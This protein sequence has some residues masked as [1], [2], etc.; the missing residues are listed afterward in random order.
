MSSDDEIT[1]LMAQ[2]QELEHEDS[3]VQEKLDG[4]QKVITHNKHICDDLTKSKLCLSMYMEDSHEKDLTPV[5][6]HLERLRMLYEDL[7][8]TET[9]LREELGNKHAK[10]LKQQREKEESK[11][12]TIKTEKSSLIEAT[13]YIAISVIAL[14]LF[15][16]DHT[17]Q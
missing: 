15:K 3:L 16:I 13:K 7:L 1:S 8:S 17:S 5:K 11:E 10:K 9:Y 4:I 12:I 2:L 6:S 14:L